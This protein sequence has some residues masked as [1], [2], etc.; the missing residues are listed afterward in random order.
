MNDQHA[1]SF[2]SSLLCYELRDEALRVSA[3]HPVEVQRGLWRTFAAT[4]LTQRHRVDVIRAGFDAIA[5]P[6]RLSHR[7]DPRPA[8]HCSALCSGL[9]AASLVSAP[10]G[11]HPRRGAR[12]G[13]SVGDGRAKERSGISIR[14]CTRPI[15]RPF[16]AASRRGLVRRGTVRRGRRTTRAH[17]QR[18]SWIYGSRK[19]NAVLE[20][21]TPQINS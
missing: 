8:R 12:Q 18:L 20:Q 15:A 6:K 11:E 1:T 9:E 7:R 21:P 4:Q 16:F 14:R 19:A 5:V 3:R 13:Q 17:L 10:C 2:A